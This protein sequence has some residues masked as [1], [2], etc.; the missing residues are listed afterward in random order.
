MLNLALVLLT[1]PAEAPA[2]GLIRHFR[3]EGDLEEPYTLDPD[4]HYIPFCGSPPWPKAEGEGPGP[5]LEG[6]WPDSDLRSGDT[7]TVPAPSVC[8]EIEWLFGGSHELQVSAVRTIMEG[9]QPRAYGRV[10]TVSEGIAT[11]AWVFEGS[12]SAG[13]ENGFYD[14]VRFEFPGREELQG[15]CGGTC[16]FDYRGVGVA[17]VDLEDGRLL[18]GSFGL[19]FELEA[20]SGGFGSW[21]TYFELDGRFSWTLAQ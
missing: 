6:W 1:T 3:F 2:S 17:W 21:M 5:K 7:W 13:D 15:L 18:R 10:R 14:R 9:H 4:G 16:E 12:I 20:T 11:L 19:T 8:N